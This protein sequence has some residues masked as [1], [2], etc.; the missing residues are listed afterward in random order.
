MFAAYW[1]L[2]TKNEFGIADKINREPKYV[3]S[4]T[5]PA[6]EWNNTTLLRGDAADV[7]RSLKQQ[8]GGDIRLVGSASLVQ[9]LTQ[10]QLIDEYHLLV[11]PLVLGRG[12]R[13]FPDGLDR[14]NLR[15]VEVR[16]FRSGVVLLRYQPASAT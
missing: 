3:V 9:A 10:T 6:A 5:L 8:P 7:V 12:R 16:P 15:L 4:S 11:H 2:Q 1:P 13:L 14:L